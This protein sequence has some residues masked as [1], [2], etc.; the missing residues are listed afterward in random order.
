MQRWGWGSKNEG[1][2]STF[3]F[4]LKQHKR[5]PAKK[6]NY[7]S[8]HKWK[9]CFSYGKNGRGIFITQTTQNE[10]MAKYTLFQAQRVKWKRWG[11]WFQLGERLWHAFIGS[12]VFAGTWCKVNQHSCSEQPHPLTCSLAN[13]L[14]KAGICICNESQVFG[15]LWIR[16]SLLTGK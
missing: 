4:N 9:T 8:F 1:E 16:D 3:A 13:R 6:K 14:S 2:G 10:L 7:I 12:E 5:K 15:K 11:K